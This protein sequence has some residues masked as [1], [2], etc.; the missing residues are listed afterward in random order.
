LVC[1]VNRF[2]S[3]EAREEADGAPT[4]D[5][6]SPARVFREEPPERLV[7]AAGVLLRVVPPADRHGDPLALLGHR[8][9]RERRGDGVR[10][11][12]QPVAGRCRGV[13]QQDRR[14]PFAGHGRLDDEGVRAGH[15]IR[16]LGDLAGVPGAEPHQP[17][18][19]LQRPR[20]QVADV[21]GSRHER[22]SRV[23]SRRV[24]PVGVAF[25]NDA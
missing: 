5:D 13:T 22:R 12:H 7:Q 2:D 15:G 8:A 4:D 24:D 11:D 10:N 19:D 3:F 17:V 25:G 20:T 1:R 14:Q 6:A 23:Y 18:A 9:R 21:K 16:E